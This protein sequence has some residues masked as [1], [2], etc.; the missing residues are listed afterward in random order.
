[1][2]ILFFV[3][4][5][6]YAGL[7]ILGLWDAN[8]R[9]TETSDILFQKA[10]IYLIILSILIGGGFFFWLRAVFPRWYQKQNTM[11]R[12]LLPVLFVI[13]S[14]AF[15]RSIMMLYNNYGAGQ[16]VFH[17]KGPVVEKSKLKRRRG[18]RFLVV[19]N[20]RDNKR[21]KLRLTKKAYQF[22]GNFPE[23]FDK[24]FKVGALGVIY[25]REL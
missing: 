22:L 17:L 4:V 15:N 9:D 11:G 18:G 2:K 25:R 7:M 21:Y 1:M 6:V 24:E 20:S 12:V 16:R 3:A 23:Y 13:Y 8:Y 19:I 14:F 5:A 10:L